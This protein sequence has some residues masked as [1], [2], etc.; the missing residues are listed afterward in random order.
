MVTHAFLAY[1]QCFLIFLHKKIVN[2]CLWSLSIAFKRGVKKHRPL[3]INHSSPNYTTMGSEFDQYSRCRTTGNLL[4]PIHFP[5]N[6]FLLAYSHFP[7]IRDTA[8]PNT[9]QRLPRSTAHHCPPLDC[10]RR[11]PLQR[12]QSEGKTNIKPPLPFDLPPSD[13]MASQSPDERKR[14]Q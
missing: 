12:S 4:I 8:P 6:S 11:R 3:S 14:K 1:L 10:L 2:N 13:L 7:S 9:A 5:A